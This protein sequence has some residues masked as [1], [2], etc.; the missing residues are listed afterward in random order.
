MN[1]KPAQCPSCGGAL[2]VPDDR[3]TVNCIYCGV[4]IVVREAIQAA[5]VASV[6]NLLR[7]AQTA[8]ASSN[9]TEAYEYFTRVLEVDSN[10]AHAWAGK[11]ESAGKLSS[12]HAFRM[13]EMLNYFGNAIAGASESQLSHIRDNAAAAICAVVSQDYVKMRSAD[14]II[15][16]EFYLGVLR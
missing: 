6:P 12:Q 5:A 2:Q 15:F 14:A 1:F 13:P 10:N 4:S 8:L 11:A 7:L 16:R 3:T 9:Y